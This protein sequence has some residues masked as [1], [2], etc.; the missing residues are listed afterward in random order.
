MASLNLVN[1][2]SKYINKPSIYLGESG[3]LTLYTHAD[4]YS[5]DMS[6]FEKIAMTNEK[7]AVMGRNNY[8]SPTN[9][10]RL[11]ITGN[12]VVV[13]TYKPIIKAGKPNAVGCWMEY[14]YKK[15]DN[16][17]EMVSGYYA[18]KISGSGYGAGVTS[19][20]VTSNLILKGNG[21]KVLNK[22]WVLSN[23]EEVYVDWTFLCTDDILMN[24]Q[25]AILLIDDV[26]NGA[27]G[28]VVKSNLLEHLLLTGL[29]LDRQELRNRYPRLK[30]V[31]LISNLDGI[32][33]NASYDKGRA[34]IG[35]VED[36]AN[37]WYG[38]EINKQLI[39]ESNSLVI[40]NR[41]DD[42]LERLNS[43]FAIR[44]GVYRF[45]DEILMDFANSLKERM[46]K[47]AREI[48]DG[49]GKAG[50]AEDGSME[51]VKSDLEEY[52]EGL[53]QKS[54]L[55]VAKRVLMLSLDGMSKAE[56]DTALNSMTEPGRRK[57]Y[58]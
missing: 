29:N 52:L 20:S 41:L 48:R 25:D 11:F 49:K 43:N 50:L 19:D 37:Y 39:K 3:S 14:P 56:V 35:S 28:K 45:D 5:G 4:N 40:V 18:S 38:S 30:C 12:R 2:L 44:D 46:L 53:E 13:Q 22:P 24:N 8:S 10:R 55:S 54:G 7:V 16:I 17:L 42:D 33:G 23:I 1:V 32:L 21:F 58:K 9:V 51:Q 15:N 31:S 26:W 57:Y 27:A 6:K 36:Y 34:N 47:H